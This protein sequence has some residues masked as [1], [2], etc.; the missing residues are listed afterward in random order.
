MVSTRQACTDGR[1]SGTARSLARVYGDVVSGS[2]QLGFDHR[3]VSEIAG[4]PSP[5]LHHS[6]DLVMGAQTR[7]HLGFARSCDLYTYPTPRCFGMRGASAADGFGDPDAQLGFGYVNNHCSLNAFGEPR[8]QAL[9]DAVYGC[10][11]HLTGP[12]TAPAAATNPERSGP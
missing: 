5:P 8:V 9:I 11:P 3:T 2:S 1:S 7:W 6:R 4:D 12:T 10:L